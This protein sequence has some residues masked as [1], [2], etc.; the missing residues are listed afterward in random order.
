MYR[1]GAKLGS[2]YLYKDMHA[3]AQPPSALTNAVDPWDI[4]PTPITT[5]GSSSNPG[6]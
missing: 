2:N 3:V 5:T 6:T 4:V 1:H